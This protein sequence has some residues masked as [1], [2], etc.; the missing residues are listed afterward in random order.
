MSY[1]ENINKMNRF[2]TYMVKLPFRLITSITIKILSAPA[3]KLKYDLNLY[4]YRKQPDFKKYKIKRFGY[5]FVSSLSASLAFSAYSRQSRYKLLEANYHMFETEHEYL[6]G[7]LTQKNLVYAH[8]FRLRQYLLASFYK[9][10]GHTNENFNTF[11]EDVNKNLHEHLDEHLGGKLELKKCLSKEDKVSLKKI[12]N[13]QR[14]ASKYQL[15]KETLYCS[16][17]ASFLSRCLEKLGLGQYAHKLGGELAL[18]TD[19]SLPLLTLS[20]L[21]SFDLLYKRNDLP[22]IST[23]N[24]FMYLRCSLSLIYQ[25]RRLRLLALF[26]AVFLYWTYIIDYKFRTD[27]IIKNMEQFA[28]IIKDE[29]ELNR[30]YAQMDEHS[31]FFFKNLWGDDDENSEKPLQNYYGPMKKVEDS[32]KVTST[33]W[34]TDNEINQ[35]L[36]F[37]IREDGEVKFIKATLGKNRQEANINLLKVDLINFNKSRFGAIQ[38]GEAVNEK[39][40]AYDEWSAY[41]K[42]IREINVYLDESIEKTNKIFLKIDD[43]ENFRNLDSENARNSIEYKELFENNDTKNLQKDI[44]SLPYDVKPENC[45]EIY[46]KLYEIRIKLRKRG[47]KELE[48]MRIEELERVRDEVR[49]RPD[50][51]HSK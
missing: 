24:K 15:N 9:I 25:E 2:F 29:I 39:W 47:L 34:Y 51:I 5:M 32:K 22:F 16:L 8:N 48:A 44:D 33:E 43:H 50:F 31:D 11:L 40:S 20:I 46:A 12:G 10:K 1:S 28:L 45:I 41:D 38:R 4:N 26:P 14:I 49:N 7:K 27:K 37:Y 17:P 18:P 21:S 19:I 35:L 23:R 30:M 6:R 36:S 13:K 3:D 42:K